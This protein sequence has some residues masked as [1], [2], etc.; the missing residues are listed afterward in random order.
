MI[1]AAEAE[2]AQS[3]VAGA[4]AGLQAG[5]RIA[6]VVAGSTHLITAALAALRLGIIP[7]VLD[8][9]TP[10]EELAALLT[11]ADPA[12]VIDSPEALAQL[13][14]GEPVAL[15]DVPLGRPMHYTSGTTG[16]RK[17][18]WSGVLDG[19][20]ARQ[21]WGE[22]RELWGFGPADVHVVVSPLYHS[23]PLRFAIGTLLAGGSVVVAG[24]F[25]PHQFLDLAT[26]CRPTTT[27]TAPA[28]LQRLR[29]LDD[30]RT[31][32]VLGRLRLLAEEYDPQ[33]KRLLGNFPQAFSHLA[34]VN[35]ALLLEGAEARHSHL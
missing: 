23:A 4:L 16:R 15:G 7:V 34:L 31:A 22:E 25:D 3:R 8:P 9:A 17:G 20:A 28:Q 13:H 1:T 29:E 14:A 18:V 26:E 19:D 2:L 12:L 33:A 32:E 35:S 27:F 30:P 5:D 11:D 21:L 10:A 24:R 6:L